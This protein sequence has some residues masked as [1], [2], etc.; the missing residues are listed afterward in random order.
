MTN[1]QRVIRA[2]LLDGMREWKKTILPEL[3]FEID[4]ISDLDAQ[5]CQSIEV[6]Y[7]SQI[8]TTMNLSILYINVAYRSSLLKAKAPP[9]S[10]SR[11]VR[12]PG[13][14]AQTYT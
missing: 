2:S 13:S 9:L 14:Q 1:V 6:E 12:L 8:C 7:M 11:S 5:S 4:P 10:K 3:T